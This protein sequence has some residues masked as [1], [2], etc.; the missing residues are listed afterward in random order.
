MPTDLIAQDLAKR[1]A[2]RTTRR[3]ALGRISR[4]V[5]SLVGVNIVVLG[6]LNRA[7]AAPPKWCGLYGIPC[8][9]CS[10][11]SDTSCPPGCDL[12]DGFWDWCC[13]DPNGFQNSVMHYYDCCKV[14]TPPNCGP[15][16]SGAHGWDCSDGAA[17]CRV[18]SGG[19]VG[20]YCC[21]VIDNTSIPC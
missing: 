2:A 13:P 17:W 15:F 8:G 10:G 21:S 1:L 16:D 14:G 7:S 19:G 18:Y 6:P 3:S 11:G 4:F 5:L 9:N 20:E 12:G